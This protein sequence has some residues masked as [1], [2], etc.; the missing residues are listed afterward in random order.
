MPAHM[1]TDISWRRVEKMRTQMRQKRQSQIKI[2]EF[3][4]VT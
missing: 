2:P 3:S 4:K 1:G